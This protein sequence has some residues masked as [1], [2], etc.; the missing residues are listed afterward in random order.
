MVKTCKL[1][2]TFYFEFVKNNIAEE[3][4]NLLVET[5]LTTCAML[6]ESYIPDSMFADT[7]SDMFD[8]I[9][10]MLCTTDNATLKPTLQGSLFK[11]L[12]NSKHTGMAIKW[13]ESGSVCDK[14]GKKIEGCELNQTLKY[15][16]VKQAHCKAAMPVTARQEL[17]T[18]VA[19]GDKSDIAINL[20]LSCKTL[21]PNKSS[22]EEAWKE[23]IDYNNELSSY[24]R[25]AM[26]DSFF[27]RD[28]EVVLAP[29][30]EKYLEAVRMCADCGNKN[31]SDAF[32]NH[33]CPSFNITD[34]FIESLKKI[35]AEHSDNVKYGSYTRTVN[36][37]IGSLEIN[38]K[39]KDFAA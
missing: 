6:L 22:K 4:Q 3:E 37:V 29:Y 10:D 20:K 13:L 19:G 15:T 32:I 28:A 36:K 27:N 7:C 24:E 33:T 35:A 12:Y 39:I 38:K 34:S 25:A 1:K 11:F 16:I 31:F 23:I 26:M 8:T 18:K 9:Y 21:I 30:F 5:I 17:L 14:S 2:S